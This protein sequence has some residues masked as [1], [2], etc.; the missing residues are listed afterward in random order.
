MAEKLGIRVG[1]WLLAVSTR[2]PE[3]CGDRFARREKRCLSGGDNNRDGRVRRKSLR[4]LTV[5]QVG[6][7][8]IKS[9]RPSHSAP[10]HALRD[11]LGWDR[12]KRG[13]RRD[14]FC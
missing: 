1:Q 13:M 4:T 8:S 12:L 11:A 6:P 3:R 2:P 9:S 7:P 10:F 5:H 14:T